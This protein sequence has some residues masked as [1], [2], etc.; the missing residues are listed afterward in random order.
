MRG[1]SSFCFASRNCAKVA[2]DAKSANE[3]RIKYKESSPQNEEAFE[4]RP[5]FLCHTVYDR[6]RLGEAG[7]TFSA[8]TL[9]CSAALASWRYYSSE[10]LDPLV[11]I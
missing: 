4:L 2:K 7:L 1:R 9:A 11:R 8:I 3:R 6:G 10:F 5:I